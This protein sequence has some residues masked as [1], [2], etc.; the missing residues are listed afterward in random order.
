M[1]AYVIAMMEHER[2]CE[3]ASR[4]IKSGEEHGVDVTLFPAVTA[5]DSPETQFDL[6]NLNKRPFLHNKYSRPVPCMA[7]FLSHRLAWLEAAREG[8]PILVL[9]HDA[10]FKSPLP[11]ELGQVTH[12][13]NLARPSFGHF[14]TPAEGLGTFRSKPGGYLGGAHGYYITPA[15]AEVLLADAH[16]AE[17]AD[18]YINSRRIPQLQEYYPWP[19]ECEDSFSTIQHPQGCLAKHN[20]VRVID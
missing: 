17:P 4:C 11:A 18:L 12:V 14:D 7:T 1:K 19:I 20:K 5:Q 16:N 3:V 2:S 10:V 9:E 13:C 6:L 8:Y 15:G